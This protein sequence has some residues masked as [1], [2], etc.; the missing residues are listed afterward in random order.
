MNKDVIY[1]DVEDDITAIIG[2]IKASKEKIVALVPPKRIGVLQSAVNLHLLVRMAKNADKQ[3]VL[4]TNN[5]ALIALSAAA[6]IP[7][8]KNLQSK[9]EI[10]Q[11]PALAVDE[12]DDIID[13]SQLPV[14]ELASTADEP[15]IGPVSKKRA[16][17]N[18]L[19]DTLDVDG[20]QAVAP[21]VGAATA[22]V[23]KP[24]PPRSTIKVPNFSRF[25]KKLFLGI[26]V[27]VVLIGF[28]VWANVFAPSAT[29]VITAK[30]IASPISQTVSLGTA[31]TN[32]STDTIQ[33]VTQTLQKNVS[34]KFTPTGSQDLGAKATGTMTLQNAYSSNSIDVPSGSSFTA[35]GLS[36]LT[37]QDVTVPAGGLS[38]GTVVP[39]TATV[40]VQASA[41]GPSYN[42]SPQAYN[43]DDVQGITA[44]GGQMSGGTSNVQTVVSASDVATA[45][46]ALDALS[47]DSDKKTLY[48]QFKNQEYIIDDTFNVSRATPVSSPAVGAQSSGANSA[49][50]TSAVTYTVSALARPDI[51]Q[52]L[53]S[54]L[55]QQINGQSEQ[56]IYDDGINNVVL[57][58]YSDDAGTASIN[59]ATTGQVGPNINDQSVIKQSEGEKSGVVQ[60]TLESIDGISDAEVK[61]PYFWV[62]TV[63]KDP[64]KVD[65]QFKLTNG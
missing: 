16:D 37:T 10:A 28:I 2:K 32:V 46:Q 59:I 52:F 31:A 41:P 63:P 26:V 58:G 56:R 36:F 25:R 38:K 43:S 1:I 62:T 61:F 21:I 13:G 40:N 7:V 48:A 4:V 44:Q 23:K 18:N 11:I 5:Q 60:Q 15:E 54:A 53:K 24:L 20:E 57:A 14:G 65:V 30:T 35:N 22:P 6:A 49:T 12:G 17:V 39:G 45:T 50:L 9:P 51:E 34:V 55:N 42:L 64:S 8:A 33:A 19:V 3:L 29:I 27:L 47:T